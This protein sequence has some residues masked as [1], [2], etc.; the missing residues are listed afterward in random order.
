V[1][2]T[3]IREA[4]LAGDVTTA[5]EYLGYD[6][7]FDGTVVEGNRLGRVLGYPTANLDVADKE[8][9]IPANG[10]YAVQVQLARSGSPG[11]EPENKDMP[12]TPPPSRLNG[13]MSI[14]VRPT[15]GP[16]ERTIEVNIFDFNKDIYDKTVRVYVK[17]YLRH[18][19]KFNNLDELKEQLAKDK[20]HSLKVLNR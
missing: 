8:K 18:E 12:F 13:M 4:L 3:K 5:N 19:V 11:G 14:G 15:I 7:F 16:S 10:I 2:S 6:Y 9:L 17:E 1:S 20:I